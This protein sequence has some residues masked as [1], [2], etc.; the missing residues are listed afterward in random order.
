MTCGKQDVL[1]FYHLS[2][3]QQKHSKSQTFLPFYLPFESFGKQQNVD[4]LLD[5]ERRNDATKHDKQVKKS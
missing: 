5:A 1:E 4:R 3:A 2:R